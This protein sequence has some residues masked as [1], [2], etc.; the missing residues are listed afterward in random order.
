MTDAPQEKIIVKVRGRDVIM[1]PANMGF[2]EA[3]LGDYMQKEYAWI[4]YFGKQIEFANREVLDAEIEYDAVY[5]DRYIKS[6]DRG[7][8]ENYAKAEALSDAEVIAARKKIAERK[9]IAGLL[10]QHHYAWCKNHANGQNRGNTLRKELEILGH[11]DIK[12]THHDL[13]G[14]MPDEGTCSIEDFFK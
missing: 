7:S 11:Q 13:A 5:S 14:P 3:T 8:T 6:K 12:T 10:K 4:D 9:E 2:N 1:D